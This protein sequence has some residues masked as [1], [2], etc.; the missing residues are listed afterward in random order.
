MIYI[1]HFFFNIFNQIRKLYLNSKFYDEKISKINNKDFIY[2]PSPHLLSSL[3][4]YQ[5]KKF[6]IEDFSLNEIWNVDN[7]NDKEY[8]NLN[9]FYWFFSLDLK[10]SKTITQ[11]V[12]K[13]WINYNQKYNYRSWN[14]DLTAKRIIAW[15]SCHNL[16]FE[17][18]D[19]YY[20]NDFN[21]IIQKQANHLIYEINRS[22][23]V[24]DKLIGCASI[25]LVGLCYQ[26]ENSYLS[27]GSNLLKNI[28]HYVADTKGFGGL[29]EDKKHY[30]V[31]AS[32]GVVTKI[33]L[34]RKFK[35]LSGIGID[36]VAMCAN[37]IICTGAKP[38]FFLD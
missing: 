4:K 20:K 32:D 27:F 26:I 38:L 3:I 17:K 5:K 2:K 25:I 7:L 14:F 22:K 21:Q 30:V 12:I 37:D 6:K 23:L 24:D 29:Y 1:S 35:M 36:L 9:S 11:S 18:S 8:K 10:S 31:G 34:P 13:N 16:T 15:L 19:E 33:I 28:S